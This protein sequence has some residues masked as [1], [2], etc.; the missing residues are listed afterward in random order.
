MKQHTKRLT[1]WAILSIIMI[2]GFI[3]QSINVMADTKYGLT[4]APMERKMILNLGDSRDSSFTIA[5]PSA[6][7]DDMYYEV[8]V[9]PFYT[10][11]S[12][13]TIFEAE[14]D[15]GEIVN[16]ITFTTPTE[17]SISPNES[18]EISFTINVP[19]NAPAGGQYAAIFVTTDSK[20]KKDSNAD[21][22]HENETSQTGINEIRRIGHLIYAEV[23]GT[24]T[25]K[26]EIVEAN[27][28]SFLLSGNISGTSL[29]KN[30]GNVHGD[31]KYTLQVFP[32]FHDEEVY[33]NEENPEERTV[34]PNR[35]IYSSTEWENTPSI[36]IFNV[37]YT[38]EFEDES[39]QIS[40]MVIICPIWLLFLIIFVIIALIIWIALRIRTHKKSS[41]K[42][43][44]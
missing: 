15:S 32:L 17:G 19:E 20:P 33:T 40:K 9:E 8:S 42:E 30:L 29:V 36:G 37:V 14:K 25:R 22:T 5:N 26:G 23:A 43:T 41:K 38:V 13:A 12:G 16:W 4:V 7:T 1:K 3:V 24:T 11:E 2:F 10:D 34:L 18:K 28:P 21:S 6:S 44:A 39:T 31:V 27:V 35:T